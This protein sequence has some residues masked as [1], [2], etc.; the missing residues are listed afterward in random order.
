MNDDDVVGLC[1]NGIAALVHLADALLE[2]KV[3]VKYFSRQ[4]VVERIKDGMMY[5]TPMVLRL[6]SATH[7]STE[8][9]KLW[10]NAKV[11]DQEYERSSID[12]F[13]AVRER[14]C[15]VLDMADVDGTAVTAKSRKGIG[16]T[17]YMLPAV[18][19]VK[20]LPRDINCLPDIPRPTKSSSSDGRSS[21]MGNSGTDG[22]TLRREPEI[23]SGEGSEDGYGD[24]MD[25][26]DEDDSYSGSPRQ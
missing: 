18:D 4:E 24:G 11:L 23:E 19:N 10:F 7:Y 1:M 17:G 8:L 9:Y 15:E 25:Y 14:V 3:L 22:E 21:E 20:K 16:S 13:K 6:D 5:L 2:Y 12:G 26:E